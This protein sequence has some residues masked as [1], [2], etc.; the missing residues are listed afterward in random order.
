M[1]RTLLAFT[2]VCA[3]MAGLCFAQN[4]VTQTLVITDKKR[5]ITAV[6]D[7]WCPFNCDP[8]SANPG[9][10]VEVL[11]E[12]L[13]PLGYRVDYQTVPWTRALA[14]TLDGTY[15]I[16]IAADKIEGAGMLFPEAEFACSYSAFSL[17]DKTFPYLGP[18]SLENKRVGGTKGYH[19]GDPEMVYFEANKLHPTK[20]SL[21]VGDDTLL[22][23][24][25]KLESGRLDVLFENVDVLNYTL[26]DTGQKIDIVNISDTNVNL[27]SFGIS[28]RIPDGP[29][30]QRIISER[31]QDIKASGRLNAIRARYHLN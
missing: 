2:G 14:Q 1:A 24:I 15:D 10:M 13:E 18:Q 30:L 23:N 9:I 5:T 4:T 26:K 16:V 22:R 17:R 31:F 29:V 3:M 28:P 20:A 6:A 12:A 21:L 19:Y 11:K 27:C 25:K 7:P 8:A